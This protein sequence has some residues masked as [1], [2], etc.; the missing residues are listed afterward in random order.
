MKTN[1]TVLV[2]KE[3]KTNKELEKSQIIVNFH[4]N[5]WQYVTQIRFRE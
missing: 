3:K 2:R 1:N 4:L 5:E